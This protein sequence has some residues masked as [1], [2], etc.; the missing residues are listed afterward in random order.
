LESKTA[1]SP[2]QIEEFNPSK[3]DIIPLHTSDR[4]AFKYCRRQWHWS[5]PARSNLIPRSRVYGIREP[6]WFGTGIHYVLER[7]YDP[8]LQEDPVATWMS[9]FDLQWEGGQVTSDDIKRHGLVDRDPV[10]QDDGTFV[11]KGL[12]DILPMPDEE[13]FMEVRGL[14]VGMMEFY[15]DYAAANNDGFRTI[16]VEHEFSI[17][18]L[19]LDGKP[20]YMQDRRTMPENWVPNKEL[21][22][23][24]GPLMEER[25]H[26]WYKQVHTRGRMDKVVQETEGI[27]R[28]GIHDYKTTSR[29]DD[30]YF[31]ALELDEQGTFYL[32]AAERE[33]QMF[34][35]EYDNVDFIVFEAILKAFPTPPTILKSGLP[36]INRQT[37]SP[38]AEMFEK[39]IDEL[40]IRMIYDND[41]KMQEYYTWLLEKGDKRF[42]HREETARNKTQR[43]NAGIRLYFEALD[44]LSDPRIYPSPK[45]EYGCINCAFRAPCIAAEDGSDWKSMI[46]D[47]YV[48]NWDR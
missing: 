11:V 4:A 40:G 47:G 21:E 39:C 46:H 29:L 41:I 24:Y 19:D 5:S 15:K 16:A 27:G 34:D 1:L 28:Y 23:F 30:D 6:L 7:F 12:R 14:G 9:W 18:V 13:H 25:K 42:I 43:K 17:P 3:W 44:M 31:R 2:K 35:L 22:N 45:K 26:V 32:W 38:T 37:E 33:A 36:S 10:E 8:F 48:A 20:L